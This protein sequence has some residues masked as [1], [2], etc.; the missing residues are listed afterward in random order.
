MGSCSAR[1]GLGLMRGG[2]L[3][4]PIHAG[5]LG[6]IL[7]GFVQVVD[8]DVV[9]PRYIT[10]L[11]R[12]VEFVVKLVDDV[13]LNHLAALGI[14]R[15]G[16]VGIELGPAVGIEWHAILRQASPALVAILGTQVIFHSAP[17]AVGR[18]L[19]ARHGDEGAVRAVDDFQIA[20]HEA[21]IKGDRAKRL[22]AFAGIF[23]EFDSH[24]G[25]IHG[26]SPCEVKRLTSR[27]KLPAQFPNF[28][29]KAAEQSAVP[30]WPNARF[31]RG[32]NR[33]R[34]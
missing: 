29:R 26:K 16:D 3:V 30:A 4:G 1:L 31:P 6:T 18:Q 24:L 25:N 32:W 13:L 11:L 19:A 17:R 22:E 28:V 8:V 34:S 5:A 27:W 7:A 21:V 14:N 15:V 12:A 9:V 23:H 2:A 20:H 33:C 10:G